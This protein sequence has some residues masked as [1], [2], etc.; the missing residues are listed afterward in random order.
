M[1]KIQALPD[2]LISQIAAGEVVERPASVL[3]EVL[4]NS[5]DAGSRSIQIHLEEGGAKL[6]RVI[7]DG[8]GI[9]KEDLA[10][11]F[12][13]HATSKIHS[14][15]DLETVETLGFRGEALASIASVARLSMTSR[16]SGSHHAW[17]LV[18]S[19]EAQPEPAALM[20]G[21]IVEMR[22]L[23]FNTPARRKFLKSAGTEFAHCQ[24]V[25]KRIALAHPEAAFS[26]THNGRN[27]FQWSPG[28]L[29]QR[30]QA[31][32]GDEFLGHSREVLA[33]GG[34]LS[35][36]GAIIDPTY[37]DTVKDQTYT[38]VN[39]RF[40]RDK[41]I[42]HALREAY[43]DVLHGHRQPSVCLFLSVAP[44]TVDVNVHPAKTEV[45]FRDSRAIHQFVFHAIQKALTA[46]AAPTLAKATVHTPAQAPTATDETRTSYPHTNTT[47][48]VSSYQPQSGQQPYQGRLEIQQPRL[49]ERYYDFVGAANSRSE[50]PA[51]E[52]TAAPHQATAEVHP[53]GFAIGQLH[54]VYIL[55]Q[56][57]AGL[58]V[59]DMHAAHERV[60]YEKLKTAVNLQTIATQSLL[61]PITLQASPLEIALLEEHQ[62]NLQSMGFELGQ[63]GPEAIV[64]RAIPALLQR[65]NPT[66]LV[67][68]VLRELQEHGLSSTSTAQR[69]QLLAT[70]ACHGAVRANRQ[71]SIPEMNALLRQMEETE[72][73][74]QCNHGRP[75]WFTLDMAQLDGM[76]LRGR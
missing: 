23:Y 33:D 46:L 9:E 7:D 12:T 37:A 52:N 67:K 26:L 66:K 11:A 54:G 69:D 18:G 72:R 6:I 10:L 58:I 56:T 49:N 19:A 39:G 60:V 62:D 53:L 50:S 73:A 55:S 1:P 40:V 25:I 42:S 13:R 75:T 17:K 27:H 71:L 21:T 4:E 15:E 68:S 8:C 63:A 59:V 61:I 70:M 29:S 43:R 48:D 24:E 36:H 3:K 2:I 16:S 38:F 35:L 5:L 51:S 30:L 34:S 31:I 20:A 14:L 28:N 74:G 45:R 32:L 57:D 41:V 65:G 22:D 64:I 76:F 44:S 47:S